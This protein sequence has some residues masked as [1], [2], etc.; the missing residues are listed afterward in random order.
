MRGEDGRRAQPVERGVAVEALLLDELAQPLQLEERRVPFVH[1]EHRRLEAER[2]QHADAADAEHELLTQPVPPVAAVQRVRHVT[3]PVGIALHL[4]VEEIERDPADARAP[5]ADADGNEIALVV[6]EHDLRRHRHECQ[7]Q[8]DGVVARVALDL[9]VALVQRLPEVPAEVVE[10][11]ADERDAEL[12]RRLQ[13]VPREHAEAT[14]I[15]REALVQAELGGEV[16][17]EEILWMTVVGLP[18]ARALDLGFEPLLHAAQPRRVLGRERAGEILVGQLGEER[19]G[20]VQQLAEAPPVEL[21]EELARARGPAEGEVPCD[22]RK[23][24]AKRGPVVHVRHSGRHPT[25][26][27]VGTLRI[28]GEL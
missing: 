11:D 15:D 13:V 19:R 6:G 23:R 25:E 5:D 27:G 17:H 14:G 18:P 12:G 9:V 20:V 1:V 3:G 7:R 2:T 16:G 21:G 26:A 10:P 8:P 28:T 22:R 4:R 24:R